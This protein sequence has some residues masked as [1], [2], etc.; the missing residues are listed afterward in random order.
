MLNLSPAFLQSFVCYAIDETDVGP[1]R[2]PLSVLATFGNPPRNLIPGYSTMDTVI[3][4][5]TKRIP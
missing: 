4:A 3:F 1:Y 5:Y 2:P